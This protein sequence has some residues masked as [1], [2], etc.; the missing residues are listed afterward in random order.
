[1]RRHIF[2]LAVLSVA[3][4]AWATNIVRLSVDGDL[5]GG[6][7]LTCVVDSDKGVAAV[8]ARV[9]APNGAEV[10]ALKEDVS[11][12]VNWLEPGTMKSMLAFRVSQPTLWTDETPVLYG[13]HV[14]LLDAKG[15]LI[16]EK[17][18]RF[19]FCR[20]EVRRDDGFYL[21]GQKLLLRGIN[22]PRAAWP[23][24]ASAR[25]AACREV[26]RDAKELNA[27]AIWCTNA[28]PEELLELCD[29]RGIYVA[30]APTAE[31]EGRHP[32][33]IRW[34]RGDGVKLLAAPAYGTLRWVLSRDPQLTL[35]VPLLP[36]E[37]AGGLGAG[38]DDCWKAICAAPRCAGAVLQAKDGWTAA[39]LGAHGRAVRE[40][41]SPIA[42][43]LDGR[44]LTFMNRNR[45]AGLGVFRYGWQALAFSARSERVLAE[46]AEACPQASAGGSAQALLPALPPETQAV[47][48]AVFD[49]KGDVV[50]TWCF[51]V[52]RERALGWPT[53][54]CAPPPGL[55]EVYF[56]AG[57]RT[58]RVRNAKNRVVQG[59]QFDFFSPPDSF[60]NVTWGRMADGAYRFDYVL[61][62]RANVEML[63]FAFPPLKDVVAERWVG[64]GPDGVWG[65]RRQ[66]APY[67]F[68]RCGAEG[69]GFVSDIDWFEI[70]TKA[71]TYRFTVIKGPEFFADR[72]PRGADIATSCVLPGFGPGF[73]VRIPGLGGESYA[74]NETGP[75]GCSAWQDFR[76][77]N[78]LKGTLLVKWTP[79]RR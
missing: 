52:P 49:G 6:G 45:F 36:Q 47:R 72:A 63:G 65:N 9:T 22:A 41:W 2:F 3:A 70:E 58:N 71:G 12:S 78:T 50:C 15:G 31:G 25:A 55:E 35:V 48:L 5:D 64:S 75:S 4:C 24:D 69:V 57:S 8:R 19:A 38:L 79:A 59:P 29:E 1:M 53:G 27:N 60:L 61:S 42:C 39:G 74:S 23:E 68:W 46:G 43:S 73:F 30:G 20:L 33:V 32:C 62:C 28:V 26:V 16:A 37:G 17:K 13:I 51:R 67:G 7:E 21:N 77:R 10:A 18:G 54:E 40:I 56:L 34:D 66:G 76:N 14:E 44:T 11:F